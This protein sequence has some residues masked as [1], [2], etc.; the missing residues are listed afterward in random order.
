MINLNRE[1]T[2]QCMWKTLKKVIRGESI[3]FKVGKEYRF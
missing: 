2:P 1:K 3:G